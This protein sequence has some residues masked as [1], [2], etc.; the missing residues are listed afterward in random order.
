MQE[1]F[2]IRKARATDAEALHQLYSRHLA[3]S[4]PPEKD[5]M[6]KRR[7][8]IE[9]FYADENYHL[10]VGEIDGNVVSS[11]TVVVVNNLTHGLRPYAVIE[12]VVTH[13]GF[14][15]RGFASRL[16]GRACVIAKER[17]CYKAMLMT[18]AKDE[19]TLRFYER[20]GFTRE[21]KTAFDKR[22]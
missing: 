21:T 5:D 7:Q 4:P 9:G 11:V 2:L 14:R 20:A 3:Q 22:L 8:L 1:K 19:A 10:L 12:N 13:S 17:N 18:G 6:A 15:G 16:L